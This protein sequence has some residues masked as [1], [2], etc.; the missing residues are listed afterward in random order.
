MALDG[1]AINALKAE[2]EEKLLGGRIY[3]VAQPEDDELILTIKNNKDQ[4]RLLLSA[5]AS[6]PLAY[7]TQDNKP[8]PAVA[9]AFCMFLRKHLTNGKI[10]AITQPDFERVLSFEVEHMDEMGDLKKKYLY[11]ELMGKHSNIILC[12]PDNTILDSIKHVPAYVSSVREVLPG[13]DYFIPK[14]GEKADPL[15]TSEQDFIDKVCERDIDI[16]KALI[17]SFNGISPIAASEILCRSGLTELTG[18]NALSD[19]SK[20]HLAHTFALLTEDIKNKAFYPSIYYKN[21]EPIEFSAFELKIYSENSGFTVS[22]YNYMSEVISDYYAKKSN[23]SRIRQHSA[24]LRQVVNTLLERNYKKYDLQLKQLKDTEKRDKYKVYGELI[25]TYGYSVEDGA[26]EFKALN[27][28][29]NKEITIPLDENLSIRENSIKYFDKYNKL[30]RTFESLSE[31]VLSTKAE[32]DHLESIS[33]ALEIAVCYDDLVQIKEELTEFGYIKKH[34]NA[35]K[36]EKILSKPFHY[37]SSDG[38]D[39]Y[40]GKN[41]YQNEEL[42]FKVATGN[43]WWFHAKDIPGSHVI[44]KCDGKEL[45]DNTF[46]EAARLALHYSKAKS[47][48][49]GD[50]DYI[51]KKHVKKPNAAKPGFVIYHTNYSMTIDNNENQMGKLLSE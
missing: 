6:M 16:T 49:K 2:F 30:K 39:M 32:I 22:K 43:D 31:L 44:V 14:S 28:Y 29:T 17:S 35:G 38:F 4:H 33:N 11:I 47:Q 7:I 12:A 25:N 34:K 48:E 27:Y 23:I 24:D 5:N 19:N 8:S 45:P 26:K 3:K 10:T 50:V 36:K 40:V 18:V 21:N 1:F 13:R 51:Q 9:P 42:T 20:L 15:S 37:V 46:E 41:N